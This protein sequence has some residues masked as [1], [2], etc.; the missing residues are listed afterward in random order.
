M[1]SVNQGHPSKDC[2][3][4]ASNGTTRQLRDNSR[5]IAT[6]TRHKKLDGAAEECW[7]PNVLVHEK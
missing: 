6:L 7:V 4:E 1:H 2:A 5:Y 3:D